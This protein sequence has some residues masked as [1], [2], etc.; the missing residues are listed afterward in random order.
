MTKD[1]NLKGFVK[2]GLMFCMIGVM[3]LSVTACGTKNNK[4]D[5]KK[6]GTQT[7]APQSTDQSKTSNK[8]WDNKEQNKKSETNTETD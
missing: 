5:S 4:S 2:K 8:K 1:K 7:E 3:T 6:P